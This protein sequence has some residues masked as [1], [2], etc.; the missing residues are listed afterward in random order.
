MYFVDVMVI[1]INDW[2]KKFNVDDNSCECVVTAVGCV[3]PLVPVG[4]TFNRQDRT[5]ATVACNFTSQTWH[6]VCHGSRWI[7]T[8]TNCTAGGFLPD[9]ICELIFQFHAIVYVKMKQSS[10]KFSLLLTIYNCAKFH[11][12]WP[13]TLVYVQGKLLAFLFQIIF[14]E[15]AVH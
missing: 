7:G 15:F 5:R 11:W 9:N 1:I 3:A 12:I 6:I 8:V 13:K 14:I 2:I 4:A 10:K